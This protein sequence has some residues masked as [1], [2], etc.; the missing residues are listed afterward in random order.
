MAGE[1]LVYALAVLLGMLQGL[2]GGG[3][4]LLYLL[5]ATQ[6]LGG[7]PK[8]SLGAALLAAAAGAVAASVVHGSGG[9]V[10][11]RRILWILAGAV[12]PCLFVPQ[13]VEPLPARNLMRC[14]AGVYAGVL[15]ASLA[16]R[17]TAASAGRLRCLLLGAMCG[18]TSSGFGVA[19]GSILAQAVQSR[20]TD[21]RQAVSTAAVVVA[22]LTL[23]ASGGRLVHGSFDL[24]AALPL[25]AGAVT[26]AVCGSK[27]AGRVPARWLS[28]LT[29]TTSVLTILALV[30]K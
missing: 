27:V 29:V 26:G 3:G 2:V 16:T 14:A 6:L 17:R 4:A 13:L 12:L 9:L 25:A 22:P 20:E 18:A 10:N 15:V 30:A 11:R 7:D 5:V 24:A 28:A 19:G 1:A 21:S 23:L 8:M